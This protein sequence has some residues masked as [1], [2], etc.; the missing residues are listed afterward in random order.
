VKYRVHLAGKNKMNFFSLEVRCC[1]RD[2]CLLTLVMYRQIVGVV[3][4]YNS[5]YKYFHL[6]KLLEKGR[7]EGTM[8][9]TKE[10]N[11]SCLLL[12]AFFFFL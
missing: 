6:E 9:S 11:K 3:R 7:K 10:Q 8:G 2:F 5:Y 1:C 12:G 4:I